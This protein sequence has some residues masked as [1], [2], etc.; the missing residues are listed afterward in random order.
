MALNSLFELEK[1][2]GGKKAV[3]VIKGR[4]QGGLGINAEAI[5]E[6]TRR[7]KKGMIIRVM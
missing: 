6:G 3:E 5:S 7:I 2:Q 1:T 4:K